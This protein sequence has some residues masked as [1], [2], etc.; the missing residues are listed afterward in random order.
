MPLISDPQ[1]VEEVYNRAIHAGICLANFCTSNPYTTEAILRSAYEFGQAH[2]FKDIPIIVSAT[3]NYAIEPQLVSYTHLKD[4]RLGMQALIDDV[5]MMLS[6]G[7]PY[8][9]LLVMLHLDH[10]QPEADRDVIERAID[11]YATI[12]YDASEWPLDEN[13]RMTRE[14]VER[15][16]G[17]VLVEGAVTEIAQAEDQVDAPLTSPEEA[18]R[19]FQDTGVFLVV[20]DLGTEHRATGVAAHYDGQRARAITERIGKRIVLHGSSSLRDEDIPH[21]AAD[22]VVKVN[23]WTTFERLGGQ[24]VARHVLRQLGNVLTED[25]LRALH[26]Q[27]VIGN[28]YFDPD[29]VADVCD[30]DLGP[31][32][33]G[34]REE[35]RR[36]AWQ[37]AVVERMAF[38][39]DHFNY[40]NWQ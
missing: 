20:P 26:A 8:A 2:G 11:K 16:R 9:D 34:L 36:D 30:G 22:G 24:A 5:E 15:T 39:L 12:M 14:F 35:G 29:Y 40:A 19:Y 17:R 31:K 27:G 25:E 1:A 7:S 38:Y 18:E 21:L 37:A 32:L 10:G 23:V 33:G 3:A 13:V 6:A 4:V 28:R